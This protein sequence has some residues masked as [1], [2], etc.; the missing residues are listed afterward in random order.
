[1]YLLI[2]V[3]F[4]FVSTTA[5]PSLDGDESAICPAY[6][7]LRNSE[8]QWPRSAERCKRRFHDT[9]STVTKYPMLEGSIDANVTKPE[10][11][12][13]LWSSASA[14]LCEKDFSAGVEDLPM[15]DRNKVQPFV[16]HGNVVYFTIVH[17]QGENE[18]ESR[19]RSTSIIGYAK[20]STQSFVRAF[21][22]PPLLICVDENTQQG[23]RKAGLD[24]ITT[25]QKLF[26]P[27]VGGFRNLSGALNLKYYFTY[28]ILRLGYIGVLYDVDS[29]WNHR[30]CV[31]PLGIFDVIAYS[32]MPAR[33]IH[34]EPSPST[35]F[36]F[37][38]LATKQPVYNKFIFC[39]PFTEHWYVITALWAAYPTPRTLALYATMVEA[40]FQYQDFWF[41]QNLFDYLL[42]LFTNFGLTTG[43]WAADVAVTHLH[44]QPRKCHITW[45]HTKMPKRYMQA[46]QNTSSGIPQ[47]VYDA[48]I[49][50]NLL[51]DL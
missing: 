40:L 35:S 49:T 38:E 29:V 26:S 9:V 37:R 47:P 42:I 5:E 34:R 33:D 27:K 11:C 25:K 2:C 21:G 15:L 22:R 43:F 31:P 32:R 14:R 7:K 18:K 6:N 23:L 12:H 1:M 3:I 20:V 50:T 51:A 45:I 39:G 44:F 4:I 13:A 28:L 16:H 48:P 19:W 8:M 10:A 30:L 24:C 41:E 17:L 46:C 36:G